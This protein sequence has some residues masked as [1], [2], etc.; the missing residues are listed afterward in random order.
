[1]YSNVLLLLLL[2]L[3]ELAE[4]TCITS[5]EVVAQVPRW[6]TYEFPTEVR[7]RFTG[8]WAQYNGQAQRWF[9][10]K[11]TGNDSEVNLDT[12]HREFSAWR[13]MPLEQLP[14]TVIDF[15]R[16]VYSQ[17]VQE[18]QPMIELHKQQSSS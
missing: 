16:D 4:E 11:F 5:V 8:S 1:M 2:L 6:L 12:E 7:C 9:L 3:Q 17:V 15:K 13:W 14:G 10:L 18:F